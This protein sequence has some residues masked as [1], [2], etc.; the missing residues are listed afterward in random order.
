MVPCRISH[1]LV[2]HPR[3]L[4]GADVGRLFP[5]SQ[6]DSACGDSAPALPAR[7][8][9]PPGGAAAADLL[10]G[11]VLGGSGA[12]HLNRS[13]GGVRHVFRGRVGISRPGP[14]GPRGR[15]KEWIPGLW[16]LGGG[17]Q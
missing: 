11:E 10:G 14:A 17:D 1:D 13:A 2:R 5:L 9:D 7:G 3:S 12:R 4:I 8:G 6:L 16:P 15:G